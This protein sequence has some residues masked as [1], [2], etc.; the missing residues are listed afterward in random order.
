MIA[1]DRQ[2]WKDV[3]YVVLSIL[4]GLALL[5][6]H[7]PVQ[8]GELSNGARASYS[9]DAGYTTNGTD[10]A[11]GEAD[12]FTTHSASLEFASEE[13]GTALRGSLALED[14]RFLTQEI[15]NDQS[16]G[17]DLAIGRQ[18]TRALLL[19]GAFSALV[20]NTGDDWNL[21]GFY[22]ATRT[23]SVVGEA[24]VEAVVTA[25]PLTLRLGVFG[26]FGR[27]G[28][29]SFPGLPLL[30]LKIQADTSRVGFD[31]AARYGFGGGLALRA[32][33]AGEAVD[34]TVADR[35]NLGR[36]PV[37]KLRGSFGLEAERGEMRLVAD[38]GGE[39]AWAEGASVLRPYGRLHL[40]LP[41]FEALALQAELGSRVELVDALDY[42]GSFERS[43]SLALAYNFDPATRLVL[44]GQH[45]RRIGLLAPEVGSRET[46]LAL[47]FEQR[48]SES[49]S[50]RARIARLLHEDN[51]EHYQADEVS[52]GFTG[53]I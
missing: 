35:Q 5:L 26:G 31:I 18:V 7:L 37:S 29:A 24:R 28:D 47:R 19:R 49:F 33:L 25:E 38:A 21:G 34:V 8:G 53:S 4:I 44:S 9:I 22:I 13:G 1:I 2:M 14:T 23:E 45:T 16:L 42:A 15:E 17:L 6:L 30:P 41:V 52:L 12:F 10:S 43:G 36:L 48:V 40:A 51:V 11:I 20:A 27:Y 32:G 46:E 3:P 39:L 50:Y